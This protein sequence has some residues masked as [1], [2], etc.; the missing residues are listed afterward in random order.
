MQVCDLNGPCRGGGV[1]LLE[2]HDQE[3]LGL[4]PSYTDAIFEV[5]TILGLAPKEFNRGSISLRQPEALT[6]F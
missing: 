5:M 6:G 1:V 3:I 2:T 4:S